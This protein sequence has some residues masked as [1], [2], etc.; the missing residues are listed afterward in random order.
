MDSLIGQS[1]PRKEDERLL[2][3]RGRFVDDVSLPGQAYAAIL[4]SPHAHA[5]ILSI[6][7]T[8]AAAAPGVLVI[9]TGRDYVADR[10]GAIPHNPVGVDHL[11]LSKPSFAPAAIPHGPLPAHLA[12]AVDRVRHV[13]E[14]VALIVAETV[15]AAL[16]A[17]EFVEVAYEALPAVTDVRAAAR[18]G[19]PRLWDDRPD[20]LCVAADN[21]DR[22][23]TAAAM[24]KAYRIIRL[25]SCNQRVSGAPMEPRAALGHYDA[26]DGTYTLYSPSQG[27][28]RHKNSMVALF[29]V[30][31][32]KV[33]VITGDVGGGF[34]V[35]SPCYPEY[36]LVLWASRRLGR[37]VKW[38]STRQ[39]AFVTDFQSRD[40]FIEGALALDRDGKFLALT[41]DYLGNLGAYPVSFAVLSNVLRMAAGVYDIP[42]LHVAVRGVTTNTLPIGVYRGAGRPESNFILERLIDMAAAELRVDRAALRQRN[43]IAAT[44]LPYQSPLGH[45]YDTGAFAEN[46]ATVLRAIDW[47]GFPARRAAAAARDM[48]AGI[49]IVNYLESPTGWPGERTDITVRPEGRVDA[50]IGTGASGQGHETSFSQVVASQLQIPFAQVAILFG[51]S[52]VAVSGGGSHSDRSMRLG[53]TVL[54]RASDAIIERGRKLAAHRLEAAEAD[55]AFADGRYTVAGTD[56][57]LGLFEVAAIGLDPKTPEVLRGPL[58]ATAEVSERLHAHPNGAVGCEL[59]VDPEAGTVRILRYVTVDDVGRIINPMIVEGQVHGGIAQ[60]VGQALMEQMVYSPD[61][62]QLLSGSFLDYTMPRADD[63]PF[64][65]VASNAI[66]T[67]SNPLGIKGAGECGTTPA[68]AVVINAI[69]DA[70]RE[71][72]VK[73]VEMPATPE[74][75]WRTIRSAARE[76]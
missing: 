49:A 59:E 7:T 40:F 41:L 44:A 50:V 3:G 36:A 5:R 11:D 8:R 4:R 47:E 32:D 66:P 16:D 76:G 65:E 14:A 52:A 12:I 70:L 21:G 64:F 29:G 48:L 51:D 39:E 72:G 42:A 57:S 23:A 63:L 1:L 2:A 71:H 62:G 22:A 38:T 60:G 33:R 35:R 68:T 53:G 15:A 69:V 74:R 61:A 17:A 9:L 37:P 19:A 28:H 46:M 73:H 58:A 24:A 18:P 25:A 20:N 27:V 6:D 13:G 30:P 10:L 75:I 55:I 34:G 26:A 43:L 45:R 67:A 54:V 56:R 31:A